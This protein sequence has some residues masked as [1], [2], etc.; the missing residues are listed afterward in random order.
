MNDERTGDDGRQG[1]FE[2]SQPLSGGTER[3]AEWLRRG[4]V[5]F[6]LADRM[7]TLTPPNVTITTA[8]DPDVTWASH[9]ARGCER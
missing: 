2:E 9:L 8:D 7:A 5:R 3:A 4:A 6:V 1:S